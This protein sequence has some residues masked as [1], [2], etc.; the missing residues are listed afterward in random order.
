M[1]F[2]SGC[3]SHTTKKKLSDDQILVR[4]KEYDQKKRRR[5]Y[6]PKWNEEFKWF[7]CEVNSDG[8]EQL[9]CHAC[10]F[11]QGSTA[12]KEDAFISGCDSIRLF[13]IRRHNET[14]AHICANAVWKA[15]TTNKV[16]NSPAV[17]IM[18]KMNSQQTKRLQILF[19]TCHGL[20]K[21]TRPF[22]DYIWH[23]EV[24]EAKGMDIGNTYRKK[25]LKE[26]LKVNQFPLSS[27]RW[28]DRLFI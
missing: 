3:S 10:K 5:F 28:L 8:K 19:Y 6:D 25:R 4:N 15:N 22:T 12:R 9:F 16:E 7:Y 17:Q 1:E 26:R 13:S 2:H 11:T 18:E 23:C 20:A 24:D 27:F 14:K 21:H